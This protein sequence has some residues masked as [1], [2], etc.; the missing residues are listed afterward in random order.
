ME[1]GDWS[2][3]AGKQQVVWGTADGMK[4]LDTINPTDYSEMA[5]KSNGRFTHSSVDDQC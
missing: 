3:R 2:I 4:L 1:Q 5:Q